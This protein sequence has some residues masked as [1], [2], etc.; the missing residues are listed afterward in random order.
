MASLCGDV[1]ESSVVDIIVPVRDGRE[2]AQRCL[3]SLY[4][5]ACRTVS[6]I[7][8]VDDASSDPLLASWLDGEAGSGRITLLRNDEARGFVKS[9][10]GALALHP[11]RDVVLIESRVELANDWLD[12]LLACARQRADIGTVMPFCCCAALCAYPYAGW[13][14]GLPGMTGLAALDAL[15]SRV[16]AGDW[17]EL[18]VAERFCMLIRRA[19]L[20]SVGFFDVERFGRGSGEAKDFSRRAITVG[21]RN[22]LAADVFVYCALPAPLTP[23]K[24][25]A[26]NDAER[27]LTALY[28]D[29]DA[30]MSNFV[31]LDP[32]AYLRL[33]IDR[34]RAALGGSEFAAVMDEQARMRAEYAAATADAPL[35]PSLPVVLHVVY[36][37]MDSDR[38]VRDYCAADIDCHNLVLRGR[39]SRNNTTTELALIDPLREASPL[40]TWTLDEPIRGVAIEHPAYASIVSWVCSAFRVRALL[41]SSLIGHSLDLLRFGLPTALIAHDFFPFCPALSMTFDGPCEH[42]ESEDLAR[43]LRENHRNAFWHITDVHYW[44]SLRKAFAACLEE[45]TVRV[46]IP[47]EEM[48]ARWTAL[49]PDSGAAQWTCI[50]YGLGAAFTRGPALP[51]IDFSPEAVRASQPDA[52]LPRLRVLIPGPLLPDTGLWLWRQLC[53]ELRLFANVMLL[54]CGEFGQSFADY[55]G[56][57]V[58]TVCEPQDMPARIAKWRPDCALLLSERPEGFCYA[59]AEMQALAVPTVAVRSGG[60]AGRINN[61]WNGFLVDADV[62]SVLDIIR[63]LGRARDRLATVVDILRFSPVR[64]AFD[65]VSDYHH[66]LPELSVEESGKETEALLAVLGKRLRWQEEIMRLKDRLQARDEE[67]RVRA[68]NQRRLESMVEALAAQHA[69][70]LHSPSWKFS[71]P[72][73]AATRWWQTLRNKISPPPEKPQIMRMRVERRLSPRLETPVPILLRSRT[74]ARY[75]LC[76]AIGQPDASVVIAG[77]GPDQSQRALQNF[78]A[79]A[80]I[81]THRNTRACF[82]WCGSLDNLRPDDAMVSKLLREVRDLFVLDTRLDAEVFAGA[83]V[84]LLPAEAV[85]QVGIKGM[86]TGIPHVELPLVPP[87]TDAGNLMAATVT[88]VL[89]YCDAAGQ[90]DAH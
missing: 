20:D 57:E 4:V 41:V 22:V 58:V 88:Q 77:G 71:A 14:G 28:P 24:L 10:N 82:V 12:R 59:L 79:L 78:I 2:A 74:A 31:H 19:C 85:S 65:M 40:M 34:A 45:N 35:R 6:E 75:W 27:T 62:D 36:D 7:I 53:D 64:T 76:E 43:C 49:F 72:L 84:L 55:T 29:Y 13:E 81:I 68:T 60:R 56:I 73:R 18:P 42:C 37:R 33:R 47:D 11:E 90:M 9:V 63:A 69:G 54:G 38:W 70:L 86:V 80:D 25:G 1:A 61:G 32:L 67:A 5:A 52:P 23:G 48:R 16:N 46:V 30:E 66:M 26:I 17:I 89:Q 8:V 87:D 83:D 39:G 15:V 51:E 50:P 3:A 21:W 44:Q